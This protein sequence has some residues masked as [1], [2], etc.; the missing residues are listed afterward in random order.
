M[1]K[2]V[3]VSI[4]V[5]NGENFILDALQSVINQTVKVDQIIIC[6]NNSNDKTVELS[7]HFIRENKRWNIKLHINNENIGFQNNFIK[8][9]DLTNT[10]YL[11]ILHVDDLLKK[12]TIEK[13]LNFF[14]RYPE[15]AII[16]GGVDKINEKGEL[17]NSINKTKDM[18]FEKGEILEFIKETASYIPF[19]TVMYN[20]KYTNDVKYLSEKSVG[21]DE[22]YWPNLLQKHPIGL[23]GGS[24]IYNRHYEGQM[25]ISN[26]VKMYDKYVKYYK[27]KISKAQLEK[28]EKRRKETEKIIKKQVSRM[29]IRLGQKIFSY[30]ENSK[31]GLNYFYYGIMQNKSIIFSKFFI[32]SSLISLNLIKH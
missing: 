2:T 15:Y 21:P 27:D 19:S 30:K 31:V 14:S 6:D 29:S 18:F 28:T 5:Y 3:T 17:L 26:S 32:K 4:P 24:L 1:G 11:V 20:L 25:H 16:G 8:C 23:L 7:K 9:Y 22:L 13:Q 10:D 12:D